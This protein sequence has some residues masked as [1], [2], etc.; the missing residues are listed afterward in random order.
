MDLWFTE[1][2]LPTVGLS[3]RVVRTLEVRQ[4][5]YQHL[6]V[7][8]TEPWGRM[9]VLDGMIQLTVAD[10]FVYHE[11]LAHVPLVAHGQ[12]RRVLVVGGGDGGTVREVLRHPEVEEVVLAEIDPEV[13]EVCQRHF[14]E[15][16]ACLDDPRVR[17]AIGDGIA[18]VA[19][20]P[21]TYDVILVDSTEPVGKA[22]GLFGESF[23]A[24]CRQALR[25]GGLMVA[26]TESPFYNPQL[27]ARCHVAMRQAF[28]NARLYLAPVPTYPSGL[29][30]FMAASLGPDPSVPAGEA[31]GTPSGLR[32]YSREVHRAA[33]VLPPFVHALLQGEREPAV[34][35][36]GLG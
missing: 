2:Q 9:L 24:S 35:G 8:E 3:C 21:D 22:V 26:Q 33:F 16:A 34:T 10:E 31:G 27:I 25:P 15:T 7:L 13:V 11:M 17:L 1:K 36:E 18:H 4:T 14:P 30:S 19:E 12:A 23:Y 28:G 29:W 32:Y 5:A 6:A 20:H